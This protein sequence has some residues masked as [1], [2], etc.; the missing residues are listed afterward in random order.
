MFDVFPIHIGLNRFIVCHCKN[1]VSVPYTHRDKLF[2]CEQKWI[3]G[4]VS[5][6]LIS[7]KQAFCENPCLVGVD[8][9][10]TVF[11]KSK[12]SFFNNGVSAT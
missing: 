3:I 5:F 7:A 9:C 6:I 12:N 1:L 10:H 8:R 2:A 4:K 11:K